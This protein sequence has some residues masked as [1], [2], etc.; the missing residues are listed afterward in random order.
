MV[1]REPD[2]VSRMCIDTTQSCQVAVEIKQVSKWYGEMRALNAIDLTVQEQERVVICG[3]SG[4]GK[5]TLIRCI[6]GLETYDKGEIRVACVSGDGKAGHR[7]GPAAGD[8]GMVFQ[9]FNL[10][11]HLSILD[12]CTLAPKIVKKM[13]KPD[14]DCLAH[15]MLEKVQISDQANK[16]PAQ[17]SGGQQQRAAIARALC[18]NPKIMLFDEPTSSLDPELVGEVLKTIARLAE[19]GMTMVIVTHEMGLAERIADRIVFMDHGEILEIN[20]PCKFFK[21]PSHERTREFLSSV[22]SPLDS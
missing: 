22:Y 12:N 20:V 17:L 13:S 7:A 4:S 8:V 9:T 14:A 15:G 2:N 3:P 10:F 5:S 19:T 1:R 11:P 21:H 16:Y 18:M 6:N